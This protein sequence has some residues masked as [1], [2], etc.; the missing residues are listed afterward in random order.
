M[1]KDMGR[2]RVRG[3]S[4]VVGYR[5]ASR[6]ERDLECLRG[7]AFPGSTAARL[8]RVSRFPRRSTAPAIAV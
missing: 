8:S 1:A 6:L 7:S 2:K 4:R 3:P 5:L